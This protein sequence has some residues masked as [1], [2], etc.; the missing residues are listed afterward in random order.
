MLIVFVS[1][2]SSIENFE[3]P[4]ADLIGYVMDKSEKRMLVIS[5]EPQNFND[6]GG[7][8]EFYDATWLSNVSDDIEIGKLVKVWYKGGVAESYP[9]QAELG[10]YEIIE[11]QK[12]KGADLSIDQVIRDALKTKEQL[13]AIR[14]IHYSRENDQWAIEFKQIFEE[15]D[16]IV[17][18]EDK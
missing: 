5:K 15:D 10:K 18:I 2:C 17:R 9:S 6:T 8:E 13:V 11:A 16:F 14:S 3:K 12:P 7:L 4:E 1:A